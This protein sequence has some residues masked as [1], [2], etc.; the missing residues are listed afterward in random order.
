MKNIVGFPDAETIK[1]EAAQWIAR[2]DRDEPL[3]SRERDALRSWIHRSSA[4]RQALYDAAELWDSL[5]ILT[6]LAPQPVE[7]TRN[8]PAASQGAEVRYSKWKRFALAASVAVIFVAGTVLFRS[9]PLLN[10]NGY[11]ATAVGDQQSIELADGSVVELNTDTQI[12]VK[13]TNSIRDITLLRGEA[14]FV[15][16]KIDNIPFQVNAGVGQVLA[17]GTA[18]S[19]YLKDDSVDVTVTEGRVSISTVSQ[20]TA[21][22]QPQGITTTTVVDSVMLD[23]GQVAI[24]KKPGPEQYGY[25]GK[26]VELHELSDRDLSRRMLWKDG[27]LAFSQA[28]LRDVVAE[29]SRYTTLEIQFSNQ[30]LAEIPVIARFPIGDTEML[31]DIFENSFGLAVTYTGPDRVLLSAKEGIVSE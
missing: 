25:A 28:P 9:N 3:S 30:A 6:E 31:L 10:S 5:N 23:A 16:A 7:L 4:H 29:V 12:K 20:P 13:F 1:A 2:L 21:V 24:I 11:Y 22:T 26:T 14:H 8:S 19:V 17:V 27:I 18:F 15:V